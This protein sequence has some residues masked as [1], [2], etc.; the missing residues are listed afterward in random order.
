MLTNAVAQIMV[1]PNAVTQK[2]TAGLLKSS[3]ALIAKKDA[4][5]PAATA[6]IPI[7]AT[8]ILFFIA[9]IVMN[10]GGEPSCE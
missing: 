1:S 8:N 7:A 10:G 9:P 5:K 2:L 6:K 3:L 4:S